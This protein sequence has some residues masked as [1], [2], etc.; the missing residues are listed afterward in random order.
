M[1]WGRSN[2]IN[3]YI[4]KTTRGKRLNYVGQ[5]YYITKEQWLPGDM[6]AIATAYIMLQ[7][8]HD[9]VCLSF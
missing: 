5:N 8:I 1:S 3:Y 2:N 7:I 4:D 6:G 9:R